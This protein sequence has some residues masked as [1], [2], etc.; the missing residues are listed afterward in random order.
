MD[1]SAL[2]GQMPGRA[3]SG[4]TEANV[5]LTRSGLA[6]PSGN[7]DRP[8]VAFG[9]S[10]GLTGSRTASFSNLAC[11]DWAQKVRLNE[12]Q[13]TLD[14]RR[15]WGSNLFSRG[16]GEKR[17]KP[18]RDRFRRSR[19][20]LRFGRNRQNRADAGDFLASQGPSH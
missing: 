8:S 2:T 5:A 16:S 20:S 12:S 14:L 13:K 4:L 15:F 18:I 10:H 7:P 9:A 17:Q 19:Q 11:R 6:G 1:L 3:V